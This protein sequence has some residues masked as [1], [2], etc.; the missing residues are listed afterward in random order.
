[1]GKLQALVA[2]PKRRRSPA[3]H[4]TWPNHI[5][6]PCAAVKE[7]GDPCPQSSEMS[8][9]AEK[10]ARLDSEP[11]HDGHPGR[12]RRELFM[13]CRATWLK[14]NSAQQD[15]S[16]AVGPC[17]GPCGGPEGGAV[18]YER[19]TPILP[20]ARSPHTIHTTRRVHTNSRYVPLQTSSLGAAHKASAHAL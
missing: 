10:L 15:P 12:P 8:R 5:R 17:L 14:R 4:G 20:P 11:A 3:H 1:M 13:Y 16:C 19:G 18:S 7:A 6:T 2:P 9:E